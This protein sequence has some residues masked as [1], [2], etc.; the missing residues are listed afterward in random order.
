MRRA[1][2]ALVPLLLLTAL[3]WAPLVDALAYRP[4]A[5]RAR[6]LLPAAWQAL[7]SAPREALTDAQTPAQRAAMI[8][9]NAVFRPGPAGTVLAIPHGFETGHLRLDTGC[10]EHV[11]RRVT[12][13][14]W[15]FETSIG[16][17][18]YQCLAALS[19]G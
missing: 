15:H 8:R 6:A 11:R 5:T 18:L 16:C 19:L 1:L 2:L 10:F 14:V 4:L 12:L 3:N 7:G 13:I 17:L 9:A